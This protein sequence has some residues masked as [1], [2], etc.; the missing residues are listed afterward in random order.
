MNEILNGN[1]VMNLVGT[2]R[3]YIDPAT[4]SYLIQ[5]IVGAGIAVAAVAGIAFS[6]IKRALKKNKG[7]EPKEVI[8]QDDGNEEKIISADDLLD[9]EE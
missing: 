4:T 3:L 9:D 5:I 8:K 2:M 1:D 7:E 6:K